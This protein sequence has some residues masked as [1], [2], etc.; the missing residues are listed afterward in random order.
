MRYNVAG[1]SAAT[2]AAADAV[3][4]VLWNPHASIPVMIRRLILTATSATGHTF[5]VRRAATRGTATTTVTPNATNDLANGVVPPSG[6]VLDTAWS[7]APTLVAG[8]SIAQS[9]FGAIG[10]WFN[11]EFSDAAAQF[12]VAAG[13]WGVGGL[14]IPPTKGIAIT[15]PI[16]TILQPLDI[17]AH[18]FE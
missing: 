13:G 18:L 6:L 4:A 10:Q 3:A 7:V 5:A 2:A 11:S 16:A 9:N 12:D 14:L 1:R 8:P 15:T 17:V